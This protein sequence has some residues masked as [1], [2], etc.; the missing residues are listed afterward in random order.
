MD[1][2]IPNTK[3]NSL[4]YDS[5]LTVT[6]NDKIY[7]NEN[8]KNTAYNINTP[9]LYSIVKDSKLFAIT[10][11]GLLILD[12]NNEKFDFINVDPGEK[13]LMENGNLIIGSYNKKINI[14]DLR[15][16]NNST[17]KDEFSDLNNT[18]EKLYKMEPKNINAFY[19]D[20]KLYDS[21]LKNNLLV[22]TSTNQIVGFDMRNLSKIIFKNELKDASSI[23]ILNE[24]IIA[25]GIYL[26]LFDFEGN[27]K[28]SL[29]GHYQNYEDQRHLYKINDLNVN[30]KI[31]SC[32]G[33]K[34]Y[35]WD[36]NKKKRKNFYETD[37]EIRKM[38]QMEDKLCIG[39]NCKD[40]SRV[41]LV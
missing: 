3:I 40:G 20:F 16:H 25:A 22:F 18:N 30:N 39:I 11:S 26:K 31:L 5:H 10:V 15:L 35:E 32:A 27:E 28:L 14:V 37:N 1:L 9:C 19:T 41:Y 29:L 4:T 23:K 33:N 12:L 38:A 34:I 21:D 13:I 36:F 24:E 2:F 17:N 7:I 6:T 8:K